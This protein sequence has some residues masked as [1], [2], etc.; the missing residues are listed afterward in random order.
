MRSV[1]M[2]R[3]YAE[4]Y[5]PYT[6]SCRAGRKEKKGVPVCSLSPMDGGERLYKLAQANE[7]LS[8][9]GD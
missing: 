2:Q 8:H 6:L 4:R 7:L 3:H 1:F 9:Q 5:L